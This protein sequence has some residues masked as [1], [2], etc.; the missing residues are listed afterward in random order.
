MVMFPTGSGPVAGN[1]PK[2][3]SEQK[4]KQNLYLTTLVAK[5]DKPHW[6]IEP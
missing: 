3:F 5:E 6:A 2:G 4:E 1:A